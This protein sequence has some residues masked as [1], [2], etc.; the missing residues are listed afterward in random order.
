MGA[1]MGRGARHGV[2]AGYQEV[3]TSTVAA[4]AWPVHCVAL[5]KMGIE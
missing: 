2:H 3:R 4:R 5:H 1:G